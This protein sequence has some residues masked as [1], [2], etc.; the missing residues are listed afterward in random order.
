MRFP[1]FLRSPIGGSSRRRQPAAR[2]RRRTR[3]LFAENLEERALLTTYYS[4][5]PPPFIP[6]ANAL[7]LQVES[8]TLYQGATP[9]NLGGNFS[10]SDVNNLGQVAGTWRDSTWIF[11]RTSWFQL[12]HAALITPEDTNGDATPDRWFR[13]TDADGVND[14]M[15]VLDPFGPYVPRDGGNSW[16]SS[17]GLGI[18]DAGQVVGAT[19]DAESSEPYYAYLWQNGQPQLWGP[20]NAAKDVNNSGQ[21]VGEL[22]TWNGLAWQSDAVLWEAGNVTVLPVPSNECA[23]STVATRINDAGQILASCTWF[24]DY[25]LTPTFGIFISPATVVEG[26]TGTRSAGFAVSLSEPSQDP[27][28]IA[29]H[30]VDSSATAGA[31]YQAASGTLTFAPGE[32]SKTISVAVLG[33]RIGE[34]TES[35]Y[36][37][38]ENPTQGVLVSGGEWGTILDDE[39]RM[40]ISDLMHTEGNS[41]TTSYAFTVSLSAP[42]DAPVTVAYATANGTAL[43]GSDYQAAS[44]TL[45]FAAGETVK[46]I[47]VLANGD[48]V[49]EPNETFVVNLSNPSGALIVANQG[50]G[51]IVDDEPRISI[52][53]V[54]KAEGKKGQTTLF[55]FT[56][57]LSAAYDQAVTMSFRT[58]DGTANSASDYTAKNGTLTFAP[59][60]TT[61]TITIEV[62]GDNTKEANE[63]FFVDLFGN[64]SNSLFTKSRGI[65][66]IL[67]D[68]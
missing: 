2:S 30:T 48:R 33:D 63:T 13:D 64:S 53:D 15:T 17:S 46:S 45:T 3:R 51:T 24:G 18:N 16:V 65:G 56:V 6:D 55:T 23:G 11:G 37:T 60:E 9:V 47:T 43:A 26:N 27:V 4:V 21:I 57:T 20:G 50:L 7:D 28:T 29:Y 58:V 32:N 36:L 31:D 19:W 67:N 22:Y 62:K 35:F 66:T 25:V 12:D 42:Y 68:D 1:N 41:G 5:D 40:T 8:G 52:G 14:L 61:K 59:G 44:G 49:A 34:E 39:P 54:S 10:A 38:L